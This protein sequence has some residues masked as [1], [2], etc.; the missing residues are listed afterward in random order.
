MWISLGSHYSVYHIPHIQCIQTSFTSRCL[1]LGDEPTSTPLGHP[2]MWNYLFPFFSSV[3][4]INEP[5]LL[6]LTISQINSLLSTR[7]VGRLLMTANISNLNYSCLQLLSTECS[8]ENTNISLLKTHKVSPTVTTSII[9][10]RSKLINV[11][12]SLSGPGSLLT[13]LAH[14]LLPIHTPPHLTLLVLIA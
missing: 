7:T 11:T 13:S 5:V 2:E 4:P 9:M 12:H 8:F 3:H 1:C 6:I 10:V 14:L